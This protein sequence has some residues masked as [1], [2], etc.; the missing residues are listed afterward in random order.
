MAIKNPESGIWL[1]VLP[2]A[3]EVRGRCRDRCRGALNAQLNTSAGEIASPLLSTPLLLGRRRERE[4]AEREREG[5]TTEKREKTESSCFFFQAAWTISPCVCVNFPDSLSL[6]TVFWD[7]LKKTCMWCFLHRGKSN[8]NKSVSLKNQ[9]LWEMNEWRC[10]EELVVCLGLNL[11]CRFS[12]WRVNC[13]R[14]VS[15][16]YV[17]RI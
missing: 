9:L 15:R 12:V 7:G 16:F 6:I 13:C 8:Q 14:S 2:C 4:T 11:E 10:A 5:G 17:C 3:S 1:H